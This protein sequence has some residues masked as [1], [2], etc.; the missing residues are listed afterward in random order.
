MRFGL[1]R[2]FGNGR[3]KSVP[4][5]PL[6]LDEPRRRSH[7]TDGIPYLPDGDVQ[8]VVEIDEGVVRPELTPEFLARNELA[9]P[10]HQNSQDLSRLILQSDSPPGFP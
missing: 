9:T 4:L 3:Y 2:R 7:I 1:C 5:R 8:A 10:R 6:R